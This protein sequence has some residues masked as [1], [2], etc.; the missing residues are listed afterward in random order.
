[1]KT[2]LLITSLLCFLAAAVS[3]FVLTVTCIETKTGFFTE[4]MRVVGILLAVAFFVFAA[5]PF[6]FGYFKPLSVSRICSKF[7]GVVSVII[8]FAVIYNTISLSKENYSVKFYYYGM[9][10]FALLAAIAYI[11]NGILSFVKINVPDVIYLFPLLFYIFRL[12]SLFTAYASV[13]TVAEH[14]FELASVSLGALAF[15]E[16]SKQ[17][18]LHGKKENG[19]LFTA[20]LL[21]A[22]VIMTAF[23]VSDFFAMISG[24]GANIHGTF[25]YLVTEFCEGI[26]FFSIAVSA[27]PA[28]A[29]GDEYGVYED[30]PDGE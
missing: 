29:S 9:L 11:V 26:F 30:T 28:E 12:I 4:S 15:L 5:I 19:K 6:I 18:V 8:G 3:K 21:A 2:K 14:V 24:N 23:A 10:F 7:T 22:A 1:M 16:F 20:F 27:Y 25:D 13:S 17:N